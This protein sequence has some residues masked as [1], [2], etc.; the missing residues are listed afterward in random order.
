MTSYFTE[1]PKITITNPINGEDVKVTDIF[2]RLLITIKELK[3]NKQFYTTYYVK[4]EERPEQIAFNYYGDTKYYWSILLFNNITSNNDWVVNSEQ[5]EKLLYTLPNQN[6][7]KFYKTVEIKNSNGKVIIPANLIVN[8]D[9]SVTIDGVLY[10][11]S[12]TKTSI[13]YREDFVEQNENKRKIL[14]LNPSIVFNMDDEFGNLIRY[15]TNILT[16]DGTKFEE[17]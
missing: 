2:R 14:L 3:N 16:E 10:Q 12:T 5:V 13:T 15:N 17:I 8:S 1:Y 9:F 11:G 7:I 4:D 6:A